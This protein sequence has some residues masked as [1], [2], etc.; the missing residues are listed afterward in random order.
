V[1]ISQELE[2]IFHIHIREHQE[3]GTKVQQCKDDFFSLYKFMLWTKGPTKTLMMFMLW[4]I[5]LKLAL[6]CVVTN[7]IVESIF[8]SIVFF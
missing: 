3:P 8:S 6:F 7:T 1:T 2:L 5:I 4:N